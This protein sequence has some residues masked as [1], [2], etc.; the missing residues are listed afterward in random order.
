[1]P[2]DGGIAL[3][4]YWHHQNETVGS[5]L[6][7]ALQL[8]NV[9]HYL[10]GEQIIHKDIKPANILIHP[11]T[12]QIQLIDFSISSLLPKEQCEL[13]NPNVLEG[14][15]AYMAPEQTGRMNRGIDY[16]SD[17][18]A[19]GV[20]LYELLTDQLPFSN[21]D[22]MALLHSH[23][24]V[25]HPAAHHIN[26]KVPAMV[27]ALIAKLM[28]K[29][30]EDRYQSALGLKFDL[31]RCY[32]QWQNQGIVTEFALGK[33]DVSDRFLI[34]EKLY[35]RQDEV[36]ALLDAFN[37]TSAGQPQLMLV[38]GFSGIG[39]TAVIN[40]IHK[41][42]TRQQGYFIKGKFDQFNRNIPFLAFVQAFRGFIQQLL[43]DSDIKQQHWKD[44]ILNAVGHNAQVILEVLPEL[45]HIIGAQPAVAELSGSAAQTRFNRIFS[46]FIQVFTTPA[47]PLVIFLDDL[48]WADSASLNLLQVLMDPDNVNT[49]T[50]HLLVLGAY[51]DNEVFA[52]HPLMLTLNEIEQQG[53]AM[54][55]LSLSPLEQ[56]DIGQLVADT[57]SCSL[58]RAQPLAKLIYQK[59]KG[60]PF[61]S[62]QVLQ[63]LHHDRHIC[64][65][66]A[67]GHWQ[68]DLAQIRQVVLSDDV[69]EFMVGR[70][71]T[72][73]T[74]TQ[75]ILKL[76]ACI[77][78]RF[79]LETLAIVCDRPR[80]SVATDLW[81]SLQL[82]LVVPESE[83]Y[84]FFQR[85]DTDLDM[86]Q[87]ITVE[88]RFLHDRVQQAAYCLIPNDQKQTVHLTIGRQLWLDFSEDTP[89]NQIF[90][91]ANHFNI[92]H[93]LIVDPAEREQIARLNLQASQMAKAAVAYEASRRYCYAGQQF[94]P[95]DSWT[96][97][98]DLR[99]A[100]ALATIE[101]EYFN[102]NLERAQE[103]SQATLEKTANLI[104]QTKVLELQILFEI[105]KNQMTDA[106]AL[107]RDV[108][109]PFD[110]GSTQG[111]TCRDGFID[112]FIDDK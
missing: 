16:R 28:A 53:A 102:H 42:I 27:S 23:M 62:T 107:A 65:N 46:Q 72:L 71:Q 88:Y 32:D 86:S 111:N 36:I 39:K 17:F 83:T 97:Y 47:H 70:L 1:M 105:N 22:P 40:E 5:V 18:Y 14:T 108:L 33:R 98:Y 54:Q 81:R 64:F 12:Q 68:A 49:D 58:E 3:T 80:E 4:E 57:L 95:E 69:V 109:K 61:F 37:R 35:G 89:D 51:R 94:L 20:T 38:A 30:A 78:N 29:N 21:E 7:I 92:S 99:F 101:A 2:N 96:H 19:L 25:Q 67:T 34:P 75:D 90:I 84:K 15:L 63:G 55:T 41:P 112:S 60:N 11:D 79:D 31:E 76:A 43:A 10:Q 56:P 91:I 85:D 93:E 6:A 87:S 73:P 77:G 9:L 74:Q 24:T 82:G 106:I 45:E 44:A 52:A 59:T 50:G 100:L 8:A 48:Q 66:R 26:P 103:L 104:D 110:I 13:V